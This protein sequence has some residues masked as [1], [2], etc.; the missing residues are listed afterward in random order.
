[1]S[2]T[3]KAIVI[4]LSLLIAGTLAFI[5]GNSMASTENSEE[6]SSGVFSVFSPLFDSVFGTGVITEKF[7]RKMAHFGEFFVLG[8]EIHLLALT[9]KGLNIKPF[10]LSLPVGFAVGGI[11]E[12]IQIFSNRGAAVKDVFIDFAGFA[13]AFTVFAVAALIK[14]GKEKKTKK[15]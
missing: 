2:K 1:M 6:A 5:W 15:A 14:R 4:I 8:V 9:L 12:I 11:D 13:L 7:F 3:R 10:L